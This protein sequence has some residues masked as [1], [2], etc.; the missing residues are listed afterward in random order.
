MK[1]LGRLRTVVGRA[2]VRTDER[3]DVVSEVHGG[4]D[5]G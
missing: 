2:G 1:R 4:A 3:E 5:G